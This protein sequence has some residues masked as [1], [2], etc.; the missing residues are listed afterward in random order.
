MIELSILI[1]AVFSR[2]SFDMYNYLLK[3]V[4]NRPVEV[5]ALFDNK[6]RTLGAKR[7]ALMSIARG[8]FITHCDDDD[9][10]IEPYIGQ[11]LQHIATN[12]ESDVICYKQSATLNGE[13]TFIVDTDMS[14]PLEEAQKH[15]G[16]WIGI[17]RKPWTWCTWRRELVKGVPFPD[18][19]NAEDYKWLQQ[20]WPKVKFQTKIDHILHVYRYSDNNSVAKGLK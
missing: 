5:L 4:G 14:Y 19:T 1:P 17:R 16:T 9:S 18:C 7:N 13:P 8:R 2:Q 12:P 3:M 11:V 15:N 20:V 10:F 6:Q